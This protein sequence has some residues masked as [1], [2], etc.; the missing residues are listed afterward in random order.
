LCRATQGGGLTA[1][2]SSVSREVLL[3]QIGRRLPAPLI[4]PGALKKVK[5]LPARYPASDASAC[6]L[7]AGDVVN[8]NGGLR[9]FDN[10]KSWVIERRSGAAW[11]AVAFCGSRDGVFRALTE[12]RATLTPAVRATLRA[13]PCEHPGA[14]GGDEPPAPRA[15]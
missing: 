8:I 14:S 11:L 4:A 6:E 13:L 9:V 2:A 5:Q 10:G 12:R 15:A 3:D 7:R 1:A